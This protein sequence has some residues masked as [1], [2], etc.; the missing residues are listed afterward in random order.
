MA[1]LIRPLMH[2][3]CYR[4]SSVA[5]NNLLS[6]FF[7]V[8]P[9]ATSTCVSFA[10]VNSSPREVHH[11]SRSPNLTPSD[12]EHSSDSD[13]GE[14]KSRNQQKREARRAVRWGMELSS[15]SPPQ[16]KRIIK[17]ASLDREVLDALM[18][19][20]R[21]GPDVREGKRRQYNYIGKLLREV[22]PELM[23][24]LIHATKDGDWSRLQGVIDAETAI[25]SADNVEIEYEEEEE[26]SQEHIEIATRWFDGLINKDV[27]ISNEVYAARSFDFDRQELRKLVRRVH[28]VEECTVNTEDDEH[29]MEKAIMAARKSLT[30]F[31]LAL[32]KQIST[33][34]NSTNS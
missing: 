17:L 30:R 15:F 6:Q 26:D 27:E 20:K 34:S 1:R 11:E 16:I 14:K 18:L 28:S 8:P 22:E 3:H 2:Y 33:K 32:S 29:E 7:I 4:C 31:L 19:V 12:L 23:D 5:S 24:S 10:A 25:I 21:L 9:R 13:S